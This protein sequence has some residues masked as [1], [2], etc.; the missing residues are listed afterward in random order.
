METPW[1]VTHALELVLLLGG[2]LLSYLGIRRVVRTQGGS[3]MRSLLRCMP[4]NP[5]VRE[6]LLMQTGHAKVS[7]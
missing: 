3:G 5:A 7:M 1:V 2:L 4:C 6:K